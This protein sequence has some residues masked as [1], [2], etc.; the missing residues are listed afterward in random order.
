MLSWGDIV[1]A[2]GV[3]AEPSA[4]LPL[5]VFDVIRNLVRP[6]PSPPV[7]WSPAFG[8]LARDGRPLLFGRTPDGA[9]EA[10]YFDLRSQWL[11][12]AGTETL[13]APSTAE[14]AYVTTREAEV[15]VASA[16][17]LAR[18]DRRSLRLVPMAT[19]RHARLGFALAPLAGGRV[20]VSGG[21]AREGGEVLA[22]TEVCDLSP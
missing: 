21:R 12:A 10:K 20:L 16:G 17:T 11:V 5:E 22:T 2:G 15:F 18:W 8:L 13:P 7:A 6:L 3:G 14:L 4:A 9:V 19:L 1:I